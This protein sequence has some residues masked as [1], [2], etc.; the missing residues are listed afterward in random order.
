LDKN[1]KEKELASLK[2]KMTRAK[3]IMIADHTGINVADI[4][5][6]RRKLKEARSEFRVTKNTL[7]RLA[8]KDTNLDVLEKYFNGPTAVVFG[9]DEPSAPAKIISTSIKEIEKPKFK[10]YF[11]DGQV[12][13]QEMLKTMA[14]LP[15][16]E[17]VLAILIATVQGPISQFI[18]VI[19]AAS[20]EFIGTVDALVKSKEA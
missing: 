2:E 9:Y 20:R 3:Q 7:L 14:E 12:Y 8:V 4:T 5:I 15:P 19:E 13:G 16:R 1:Q 11:V 18:S 10:A 6:L 17:V